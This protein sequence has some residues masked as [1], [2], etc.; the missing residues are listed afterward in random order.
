MSLGRAQQTGRSHGSDALMS[1]RSDEQPLDLHLWFLCEFLIQSKVDMK[2]LQLYVIAACFLKMRRRMNDKNNISKFYYDSLTTLD[3]SEFPE[4][5]EPPPSGTFKTTIDKQLLIEVLPVL[6]EHLPHLPM[7]NL[8]RQAEAANSQCPY[9]IYTE[10]TRI[11]FHAL[12]CGLL[13]CYKESLD[14]LKTYHQQRNRL[15]TASK[16]KSH[17]STV[18]IYGTA[19]QLLSRGSAINNHLKAIESLLRD[20][21]RDKTADVKLQMAEEIEEE[22]EVDAELEG[23]TEQPLWESYRD[24]LRLMVAHFEAVSVLVGHI[25]SSKFQSDKI[26]IKILSAPRPNQAM[27]PWEDLLNSKYFPAHTLNSAPNASI[28]NIIDSLKMW[29]KPEGNNTNNVENVL[30]AI[31]KLLTRDSEE[32]S[33][34]I[35]A[36]SDEPANASAVGLS[37]EL[38]QIIIQ[39]KS[40]KDCQSPARDKC[41]AEIIATLSN[42]PSRAPQSQELIRG[43]VHMLESLRDGAIIFRQ[44]RKNALKKGIGFIGSLHCELIIASLIELAAS[45]RDS[46][47]ALGDILKEFEVSCIFLALQDASDILR[48]RTVDMS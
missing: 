15:S 48:C 10:D 39:L 32:P 33:K 34:L 13:K 28:E 18:L 35:V 26:V 25:A 6:H 44:L 23:T 8:L 36:P 1:Y 2:P 40:L 17:L 37:P 12:L 4:F 46:A 21:R 29:S 45:S 22:V 30:L 38:E 42:L 14:S 41:I 5:I 3:V 43:V 47:I 9:N 7:S 31:Q 16:F 24:W 20:H 27:L 11:E 19:L